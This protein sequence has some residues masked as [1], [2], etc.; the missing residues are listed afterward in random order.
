MFYGI[1]KYG[2]KEVSYV[3]L[4]FFHVNYKNLKNILNQLLFILKEL[5][6]TRDD[7]LLYE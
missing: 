7:D 2:S 3:A 1:I 6:I 4:G 5:V